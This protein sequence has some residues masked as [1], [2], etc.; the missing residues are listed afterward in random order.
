MQFRRE[1]IINLIPEL[2]PLLEKHYLEIAHY[3]DIA[4]K[5]DWDTYRK[6]EEANLLRCF[7][8]RDDLDVLIG[9]CF[10]FIKKNIH[11]SDSLQASQDVL[12]LHPDYR[13]NHIGSKFL[14]WCDDQ[15]RD[16]GIQVVYHHVKEAHNFGKLLERLDYKLVDL[17]YSRRLDKEKAHGG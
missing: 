15:L 17:I 1:Q 11:Y 10:F 8:V 7:T 13:K 2:L 5:P 9:Y 4:L 12:F 16:E 6:I 14:E 3:Q